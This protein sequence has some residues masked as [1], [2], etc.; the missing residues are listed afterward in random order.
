[1]GGRLLEG[2]PWLAGHWIGKA[3][4]DVGSSRY[5]YRLGHKARRDGP[6]EPTPASFAPFDIRPGH[7]LDPTGTDCHRGRCAPWLRLSGCRLWVERFVPSRSHSSQTDLGGRCRCADDLA[8]CQ[9]W[10]S[11]STG[12]LRAHNALESV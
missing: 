3:S 12:L 9:A 5:L 7:P 6:P 1:M 8:G 4:L 2:R 10:S 11:E